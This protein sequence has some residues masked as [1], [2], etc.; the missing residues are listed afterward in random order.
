MSLGVAH[1]LPTRGVS[2]L[3]CA[4]DCPVDYNLARLRLRPGQR[5]L[6]ALRE[7]LRLDKDFVKEK[8]TT[9]KDIGESISDNLRASLEP[10]S[11]DF[12]ERRLGHDDDRKA[13]R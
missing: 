5:G 6:K 12:H 10:G 11:H 4:D 7:K 2:S 9:L 3:E 8:T 13:Q 1:V